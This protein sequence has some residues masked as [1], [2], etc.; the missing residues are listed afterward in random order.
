[1]ALA[2][3]T[4]PVPSAAVEVDEI[5]KG[6]ICPER[7]LSRF[8]KTCPGGVALPAGRQRSKGLC[9]QQVGFGSLRRSSGKRGHPHPARWRP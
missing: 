5:H 7:S 8:S 4:K 3:P 2:I 1:V 9:L 6:L